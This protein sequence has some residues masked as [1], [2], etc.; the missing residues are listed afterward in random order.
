MPDSVAPDGAGLF[1]WRRPCRWRR[2]MP[3]GAG[4]QPCGFA[5]VLAGTGPRPILNH[6]RRS[7]G[8][9]RHGVTMPRNQ[10]RSTA[11]RPRGCCTRA[12]WIGPGPGDHQGFV[13]AAAR[14][15]AIFKQRHGRFRFPLIKMQKAPEGLQG[16]LRARMRRGGTPICVPFASA[17]PLRQG[18]HSSRWRWGSR[19][20]GR[21]AVRPDHPER[22]NRRWHRGALGLW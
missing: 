4:L 8:P 18:S 19:R 17:P 20:P 21:C 7:Q 6:Q 2:A 5:L 12:G 11:Y 1:R 13:L 9:S 15:A 10:T 16:D 14:L 3:G 22:Q